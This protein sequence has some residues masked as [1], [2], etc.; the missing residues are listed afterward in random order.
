MIQSFRDEFDLGYKN[1]KTL[2]DLGSVF[3][4]SDDKDKVSQKRYTHYRNGVGYLLYMTQWWSPDIQYLVRDVPRQGS[5]LVKA[6]VK[7]IHR[8]M[9]YDE[10]TKHK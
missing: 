5:A 7:E 10:R 8:I 3:M 1:T 4:K 2:A 9:E 6:H